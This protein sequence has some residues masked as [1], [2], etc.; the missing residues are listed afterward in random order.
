MDV[1]LIVTDGQLKVTRD[2]TLLLVITRSV[3]RKLKN[4]R[5][6]VLKDRSKVN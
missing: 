5:S 6:E 1:L 2:D 3:A 4:L